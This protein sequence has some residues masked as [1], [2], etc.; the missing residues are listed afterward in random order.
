[1][2]MESFLCLPAWGA[3]L[4]SSS[5]R[6]FLLSRTEK[7]TG[8][9]GPGLME[10]I[11]TMGRLGLGL[12]G[13][14]GEAL[15]LGALLARDRDNQLFLGLGRRRVWAKT[16][17]QMA[18]CLNFGDGCNYLVNC[19]CSQHRRQEKSC[20]ASRNLLADAPTCSYTVSGQI[21]FLEKSPTELCLC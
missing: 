20:Q 6:C 10:Y 16:A 3:F 4:R 12:L 11:A 15:G 19:S 8:N 1:M 17:C 21:S 5:L 2:T 9:G 14:E 7:C 18:N 13:Q